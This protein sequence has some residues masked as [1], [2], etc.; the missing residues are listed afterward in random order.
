MSQLLKIDKLKLF[1][2]NK[3]SGLLSYHNNKKNLII[4][5]S[6]IL[7]LPFVIFVR[8]ISPIKKITI[9]YINFSRIGEHHHLD[10][11]LSKKKIGYYSKNLNLFCQTFSHY[12]DPQICNSF[13]YK[14]WKR[15]LFII[16]V[17]PFGLSIYF[18]HQKLPGKKLNEIPN[19]HLFLDPE[20]HEVTNGLG[21]EKKDKL[22]NILKAKDLNL[23]LKDEEL[24]EGYKLLEKINVTKDSEFVCFQNR[25]NVYLN[26]KDKKYMK[27]K[28]W[29]W[30]YHDYRNSKI[31]NYIL[32]AKNLAAEGTFAIYTGI[33]K[34]NSKEKLAKE[35]IDFR[36]SEINSDFMDIFLANRCKFYICSDSGISSVPQVFRKPIVYVSFPSIRI[37]GYLHNLH[38]ITIIKKFYSKSKKRL[39][40]F[41]EILEIENIVG[42]FGTDKFIKDFNDVEILENSPEEINEAVQ[43]MQQR[44]NGKWKSLPEDIDFQNKFWQINGMYKVKSANVLIGAKFLRRYNHLL[45]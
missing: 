13:W 12:I 44:L 28:K 19:F 2:K 34:I 16:P 38:S 15:Y 35:I 33:G 11:F 3:I 14:L 10:F 24:A 40:T 29:D 5:T 45:V 32:A 9:E 25:D 18:W 43:E 41:K 7:T 21:K 30:S 31:E 37:T 4:I 22:S 6:S 39:L 42:N 23:F 20:P 17:F 26:T 1:L 36:R 8:L 27:L